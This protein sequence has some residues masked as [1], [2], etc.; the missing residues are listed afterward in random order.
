MAISKLNTLIL[1]IASGLRVAA[2]QAMLAE[3]VPQQTMTPAGSPDEWLLGFLDWR[4]EQVP[5]V[6]PG[7]VCGHAAPDAAGIHR[8]GVLY[9]L[10]HIVGLSYYAVPLAAIPHPV[11]V[12]AEDVLAEEVATPL[13]CPA[14]AA[15]ARIEGQSVTI[16]DFPYL[17]HLIEQQLAR[18]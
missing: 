2:P 3:V 15:M 12:G 6:D 10:E 14:V 13:P 18:L 4:G 5:V 16:P 9:A 11:R 17:E 1:D 7:V 8:Y